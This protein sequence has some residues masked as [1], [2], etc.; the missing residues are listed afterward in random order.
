MLELTYYCLRALALI[1][2]IILCYGG[3]FVVYDSEDAL[4]QNILENWWVRIDDLKI[5]ALSSHVAFMKGAAE[6]AS[7]TLD[8]VFGRKLISIR[9]ISVTGCLSLASLN[10]LTT[11]IQNNHFLLRRQL[12]ESLVHTFNFE[13]IDAKNLAFLVESFVEVMF[14][15]VYTDLIE[16]TNYFNI[17]SFLTVAAVLLPMFLKRLYWLPLLALTSLSVFGLS[18][19][20]LVHNNTTAIFFSPQLMMFITVLVGIFCDV[21]AISIVRIL[22]RW[23]ADWTSFLRTLIMA[24][25]QLLT[26]IV[27]IL[28]PI[29]VG[30]Y[31]LLDIDF[32]LSIWGNILCSIGLSAAT[33]IISSVM[34]L[35]FFIAGTVLVVHR[36]IWPCIT[37][38][39]YRLIILYRTPAMKTASCCLG[40]TLILIGLG[41]SR[42]L[43]SLFFIFTGIDR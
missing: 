6:F 8:R 19:R 40:F 24:T 41:K 2:G 31:G 25:L 26:A 16:H 9:T 37:R 34:A 27:L 17:V 11:F 5:T 36:L 10:L 12:L 29:L 43:I 13:Y 7:A 39:L 20:E 32:T 38:L 21:I 3:F 18:S 14:A 42:D 15:R 28:F 22:L 33:N 35:T 1:S 4:V 23:Q 30:S